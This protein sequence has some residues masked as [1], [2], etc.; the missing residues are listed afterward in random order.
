MSTDESPVAPSDDA[1][2]IA[3]RL[4]SR[5]E[6]IENLLEDQRVLHSVRDAVDGLRSVADLAADRIERDAA[7]VARLQAELAARDRDAQRYRAIRPDQTEHGYLTLRI[8]GKRTTYF[9]GDALDRD[10]AI[11]RSTDGPGAGVGNELGRGAE[12]APVRYPQEGEAAGSEAASG[13]ATP[14]PPT[15][16]HYVVSPTLQAERIRACLRERP[17]DHHT[18]A[19]W[20]E[21]VLREWLPLA[22][23]PQE[24][25][26]STKGNNDGIGQ[27][28][29]ARRSQRDDER[30]GDHARLHSGTG[31]GADRAGSAEDIDE[32]RLGDVGSN[33]Q[34]SAGRGDR[35]DAIQQQLGA[36]QVG[37]AGTDGS[38]GAG[39]TGTRTPIRHQDH[40]EG[41][42]PSQ[43]SP[44]RE[45]GS[46]GVR[47]DVDDV[48]DVVRQEQASCMHPITQVKFRAGLLA[49]REYMAR[50]L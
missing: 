32:Q 7:Y 44:S 31:A 19:F 29:N 41:V 35:P 47:D 38:E 46:P 18:L 13:A 48:P 37:R 10:I 24:S 36:G 25:P 39:E 23:L 26:L 22:A 16:S 34:D 28:D 17:R 50:F 2:V 42:A 45:P 8:N 21:T 11:Y 9:D 40:Q 1:M 6:E 43:E 27:S 12:S 33:R 14:G 3:L 30:T 20:L 49:C 4:C 5:A 15:P